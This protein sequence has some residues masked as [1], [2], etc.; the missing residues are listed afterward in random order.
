MSQPTFVEYNQSQ[1]RHPDEAMIQGIRQHSVGGYNYTDILQRL[2]P[3]GLF[4]PAINVVQASQQA[5]LHVRNLCFQNFMLL[6]AKGHSWCQEPDQFVR[7]TDFELGL[8]AQH[9]SILISLLLNSF[10][11]STYI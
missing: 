7:F 5:N 9:G 3:N 1:V 10:S 4:C 8:D 2:V 11:K 6:E